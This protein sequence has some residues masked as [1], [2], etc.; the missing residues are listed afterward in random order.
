MILA[1]LF[2]LTAF[3][4]NPP[5]EDP[6]TQGPSTSSSNSVEKPTS[7]DKDNGDYYYQPLEAKDAIQY[8]VTERPPIKGAVFLRFGTIGPY[9]I[10]SDTGNTNYK[11]VYTSSPSILAYVEYEKQLGHF[12]GKWAIKLGTGVSSETAPGHF[13]TPPT[14]GREPKEKFS[15]V[16]MP[17]TAMLNYKLRFSDK[18]IITPYFEGGG[19]YFTFV[20]YRN[21]G[22]HTAYGGAP[23]A[24][25]AGGLLISIT[26]FDKHASSVMYEEYGITHLWFD[27]QVR[28][29][30]G[31]GSKDFSSNMMTAGFG[32][33]F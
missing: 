17:N 1:A 9:Q 16:V 14:S 12:L 4:A 26:N 15:F 27:M 11:D 5:L 6:Y 2:S 32:F 22:N 23:I 19:G 10:K 7:I 8:E 21:D 3:A 31:A 25:V 20:E 24:A 18:Q 13:E 28:R 29:N 30:Q 33:A